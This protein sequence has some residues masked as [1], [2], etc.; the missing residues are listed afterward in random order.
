MIKPAFAINAAK[1]SVF[2]KAASST[3]QCCKYEN[4]LDKFIVDFSGPVHKIKASSG[5]I[6]LTNNVGGNIA[7]SFDFKRKTLAR[8]HCVA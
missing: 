3:E 5:M 7:C 8:V 1:Y 4:Y 2:H 6:P